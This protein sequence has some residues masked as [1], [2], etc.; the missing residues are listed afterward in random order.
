MLDDVFG[1]GRHLLERV[2]TLG[3]GTRRLER[4]QDA[5]DPAAVGGALLGL[6]RHVVASEGRHGLN[7]LELGH[8]AGEVE[9]EH[10]SP[11]VAVQVQHPGS[12]AH[13]LRRLQHLRR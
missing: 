5:G 13:C 11:V 2:S 12:A 4:E 1:H 6:A 10:V 9:V 8:V 3:G 7:A